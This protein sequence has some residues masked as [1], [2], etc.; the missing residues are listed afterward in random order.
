[1]LLILCLSNPSLLRVEKDESKDGD[2]HRVRVAPN[3]TTLRAMPLQTPN[4]LE[5]PKRVGKNTRHAFIPQ[6]DD[7]CRNLDYEGMMRHKEQDLR[8]TCRR[9]VDWNDSTGGVYVYESAGTKLAAV[10]D[11]DKILR[12]AL[13][14]LD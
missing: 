12:F 7:L 14:G 10:V 2:T 5:K 3:S 1:M 6:L 9:H 4:V 13:S 8:G 11:A